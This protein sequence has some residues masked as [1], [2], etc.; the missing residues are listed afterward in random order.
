MKEQ[1]GYY[2]ENEEY[3]LFMKELESYCSDNYIEEQSQI[4]SSKCKL[5]YKKSIDLSVQC[6]I[7]EVDKEMKG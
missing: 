2:E 3:Y 1:F 5:I 7:I 6:V 4:Y